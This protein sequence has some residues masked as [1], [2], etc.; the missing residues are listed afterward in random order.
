MVTF[1]NK[2]GKHVHKIEFKKSDSISQ[3][4]ANIPVFDQI[5]ESLKT[6]LPFSVTKQKD[7]TFWD[8]RL[9]A[10]TGHVFTK[11]NIDIFE[12]AEIEF[13]YDDLNQELLTFFLENNTE[14]SAGLYI[15]HEERS[16]I[17]VRPLCDVNAN[18]TYEIAISNRNLDD[19]Y[20]MALRKNPLTYD[21][22]EVFIKSGDTITFTIDDCDHEEII[23]F[24]TD[25]ED[26]D[27]GWIIENGDAGNQWFVGSA[28]A[29]TGERSIYISNDNG[30]TN[31]YD[32]SM[33]STVYFYRS[34]TVPPETKYSRIILDSQEINGSI[35]YDFLDSP[36]VAGIHKKARFVGSNNKWSSRAI[37]PPIGGSKYLSFCFNIGSI[38]NHILPSVAIDN[39]KLSYYIPKS[40]RNIIYEDRRIS[41]DVRMD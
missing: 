3:W 17:G 41:F 24:N 39:I 29:S 16:I 10:T 23:V 28:I 33:K 2:T 37:I 22:T 14:D 8:I 35:Q 25:F 20:Y 12:C 7:G 21:K 38:G 13:I 1:I 34:I 31:S 32:S 27:H 40:G 6:M 36:P 9:L 4:G 15:L 11:F 26:D 30:L 19:I 18:Q 5:R